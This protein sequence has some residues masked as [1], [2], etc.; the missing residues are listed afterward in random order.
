MPTPTP[1]REASGSSTIGTRA[2]NHTKTPRSSSSTLRE[3]RLRVPVE[4]RSEQPSTRLQQ[5][6]PSDRRGVR[7]SAA[8]VRGAEGTGLVELQRAHETAR[9]RSRRTPAGRSSGRGASRRDRPS[10][11]THA[12]IPCSSATPSWDQR[13]SASRRIRLRDQPG[14]KKAPASCRG[15]GARRRARV[16]PHAR[17][18]DRGSVS[19][20][21]C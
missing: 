14:G 15:L 9:P 4:A 13:P 1:T 12:R 18:R 20:S 2:P 17:A 8:I 11:R 3:L 5:S 10:G 21:S 7:G 16:R 6:A 19:R